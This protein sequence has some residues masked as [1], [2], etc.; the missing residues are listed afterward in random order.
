MGV[1]AIRVLAGGALSG[2]SARHPLG[3]ASVAPIASGADY[4]ADVA[5][6]QQLRWLVEGGYAR[7]LPEAAIRFALVQPGIATALVGFSSLDQ[8]EQAIVAAEKG[9]LP[10]EAMA[11]LTTM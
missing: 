9:P 7:S 1:I 3:A 8:L 10:S 4:A 2:E 6:A 11:Q 5:Q